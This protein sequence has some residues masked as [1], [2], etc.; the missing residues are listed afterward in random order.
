MTSMPQSRVAIEA[1]GFGVADDD[2]A[3][4]GAAAAAQ[5]DPPGVV[6]DRVCPRRVDVVRAAAGADVQT[7]PMV[8]PRSELVGGSHSRRSDLSTRRA[9]V[10][11]SSGS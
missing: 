9:R 11:P 3:R 7:A 5:P 2:V 4:V 6:V 8:P 1:G 10:G